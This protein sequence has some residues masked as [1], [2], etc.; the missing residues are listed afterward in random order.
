M[1]GTTSVM[2][3]SDSALGEVAA[4]RDLKNKVGCEDHLPIKE[5]EGITEWLRGSLVSGFWTLGFHCFLTFLI[6]EKSEAMLIHS[7]LCSLSFHFSDMCKLYSYFFAIQNLTLSRSLF[8][9]FAENIDYFQ[10]AYLNLFF[11]DSGKFSLSLNILLVNASTWDVLIHPWD[12]I[13]WL[14]WLSILICMCIYPICVHINIYAH[15]YIW[16]YKYIS[17]D[18]ISTG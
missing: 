6:A 7:A 15:L 18:T 1:L 14:R 13:K 5:K 17:S 4:G 9:G 16:M 12:H 8:S 2:A 11:F 10:S 3:G